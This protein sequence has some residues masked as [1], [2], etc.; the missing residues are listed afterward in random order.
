M[1]PATAYRLR[2]VT[3]AAWEHCLAVRGESTS[4]TNKCVTVLGNP[5]LPSNAAVC[6]LKELLMD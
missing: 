3:R 1:H 4:H 5:P 6:P 2:A